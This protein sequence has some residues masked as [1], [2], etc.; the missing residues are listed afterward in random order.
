MT[1]TEEVYSNLDPESL[2]QID[3][4]GSL[5]LIPTAY[6]MYAHEHVN[7]RLRGDEGEAGEA[8]A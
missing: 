4:G 2:S 8:E 3:S 7:S 5:K 1:G 6:T